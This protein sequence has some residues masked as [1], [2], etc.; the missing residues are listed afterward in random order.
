MGGNN[1]L[2][3]EDGSYDSYSLLMEDGSYDSYSLL[4]E[5][6]S[7]DSYNLLLEEDGSYDSYNLL[8]EEDGSYDSYSL[9]M[10]DGSYD[11]Y[12]LLEE[13]GSYD[14]Y[15][16]LEEDG[17]YDSYSLLM[18]DGSYDSYSL[19]MEDGSFDSYSLLMEDGSYDSYALEDSS[20]DS[21]PESL[22]NEDGV[23]SVKFSMANM[24]TCLYDCAGVPSA[25]SSESEWCAH[26][27][28][29]AAAPACLSDCSENDVGQISHFQEHC[30]AEVLATDGTVV[31]NDYSG[32]EDYSGGVVRDNEDYN[33]ERPT[34]DPIA[35][36]AI[37]TG[38]MAATDQTYTKSISSA[39]A[40]VAKHGSM[41]ATVIAGLAFM[42][43]VIAMVLKARA[44][45]SSSFNASLD[46]APTPEADGFSVSA[47]HAVNT[48]AGV[49]ACD[50]DFR[51]S[52]LVVDGESLL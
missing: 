7:Y 25:T 40:M 12:S 31:L 19:L 45:R 29:Y 13:D 23:L 20:F 22:Y 26:V 49:S 42:L 28:A 10:E 50:P 4:M 33:D 44:V 17:S 8:L 6:G 36:G 18:E 47:I 37:A 41:L 27:T 30:S 15:S 32:E 14:S 35:T 38:A 11:S 1:L 21:S 46:G 24:P 16:L 9:L 5:D 48:H 51:A 2:L 39:E 34:A 3:E 52:S 43:T